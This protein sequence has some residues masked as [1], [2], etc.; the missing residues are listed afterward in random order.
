LAE[1]ATGG[2]AGAADVVGDGKR[3]TGTLV[4]SAIAVSDSPGVSAGVP[5]AA[6][7]V[8]SR[9]SNESVVATRGD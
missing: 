3:D 7:S 8:K 5:E 9:L 6:A 4:G 1:A 2:D